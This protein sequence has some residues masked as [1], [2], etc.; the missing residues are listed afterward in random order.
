MCIYRYTYRITGI[1]CGRKVSRI[2]FFV[3]VRKKTFAIQAISYIKIPAE[4]KS[5]R[6][7]SRILPDSQN[8]RNFSSADDSRYTVKSFY[9]GIVIVSFISIYWYIDIYRTSL[10]AGGLIIKKLQHLF[11]LCCIYNLRICK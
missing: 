8:S 6:K 10:I 2:V 7:H 9:I 1:I 4:I 11:Q 5:A 3:V